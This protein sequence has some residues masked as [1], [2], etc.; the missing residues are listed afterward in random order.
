MKFLKCK[1]KIA[2]QLSHSEIKKNMKGPKLP[3]SED[4][5]A[6]DEPTMEKIARNEK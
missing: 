1:R 3:L 5:P 6:K 2:M 4:I